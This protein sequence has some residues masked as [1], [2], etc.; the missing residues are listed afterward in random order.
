MLSDAPLKSKKFKLRAMIVFLVW[1]KGVTTKSDRMVAP[2][3]LLLRQHQAQPFLGGMVCQNQGRPTWEWIES[4][5]S[6]PLPS[7]APQGVGVL[8]QLNLLPQYI[9][10]GPCDMSKPLNEAPVMSCQSTKHA[11]GTPLPCTCFLYWDRSPH[12]K[13][14]VLG[15]QSQTEKMSTWRVSTSG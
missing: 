6:G 9:V 4:C 7:P 13:C 8:S 11:L 2:I 14:D 10:E 12:G 15:I 1:C 3:I 5:L